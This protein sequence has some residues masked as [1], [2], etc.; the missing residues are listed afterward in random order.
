MWILA[1][2][3]KLR[4]IEV[5][6]WNRNVWN[7]HHQWKQLKM[8]EKVRFSVEIIVWIVSHCE[9]KIGN[10]DSWKKPRFRTT[11]RILKKSESALAV[12]QIKFF[13]RCT[14]QIVRFFQWIQGLD[15]ETFFG[16]H[17]PKKIEN[18]GNNLIWSTNEALN[19]WID[20]QKDANNKLL[21]GLFDDP[22]KLWEVDDNH[23]WQFLAFN[24]IW[25]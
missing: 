7:A 4:Q 12:E 18:Y 11:T 19:E 1:G 6:L 2:F 9:T 5:G 3:S 15:H 13:W 14:E 25:W 16:W 21:N 23:N 17:L 24:G 10:T 8:R 20:S 22:W